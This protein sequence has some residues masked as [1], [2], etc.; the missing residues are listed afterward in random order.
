MHAH[1]LKSNANTPDNRKK[2][3]TKAIIRMTNLLQLSRQELS[4]II[5]PSEASLSRM[6]TKAHAGID[7]ESK[8]GQLALLLLRLYRSLDALF[9]GNV[10]QCQQWLRSKNH[11]LTG[12]P[13]TMMQSIE[14]LIFVIQYLDAM[15]GKN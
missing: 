4:A 13:I 10:G 7:P 11:H 12:T 15:R 14:G 9:G 1:R 3:L 6:F 2:V 5:G 8:E